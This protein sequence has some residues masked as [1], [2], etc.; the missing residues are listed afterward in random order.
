MPAV[1][2]LLAAYRGEAYLD[3]QL[4]SILPQLEKDDELLISDDSPPEHSATGELARRYAR[5]DP[6]VTYLTGP[7]QGGTAK[8]IEFLLTRARREILVL[9]DQD[10]LW[11]PDKLE[12]IRTALSGA[13]GPLCLLHDAKI[14]NGNL[15]IIEPSFMRAHGSRPGFWRNYLRNGYIG[16]CMA[17]RRELLPLVLP[18]P[19][20]IPMHDQWLGLR[21]E[22]HGGVLWLDEPLLLYRRHS[23]TQTGHRTTMRQKIIWR[24]KLGAALI[25]Q[26]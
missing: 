14:T 8:N 22:R 6:R 1:S 20:G 16:C 11:L 2:V 9:S 7:R 26:K 4:G 12:K 24:W 17:L 13:N 19:D 23:G 21:A 10:D 18:F 25:K 5:Q 3:A 15:E